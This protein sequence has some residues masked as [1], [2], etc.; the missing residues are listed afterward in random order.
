MMVTVGPA[1]YSRKAGLLSDVGLH[2]NKFGKNAVLIGGN[3]SREIIEETLRKSLSEHGMMV[4][5]SLW[6]GGESSKTNIDRLV[7]QLKSEDFDLLIAAGGG[8]AIDTVKAVAYQ[9]NK[10]LVAIPTI[11]ATC[12]AATPITILYSD[13]GEFLEIGRDSKAPDLVL[14]D[15]H[16]I[17]HA[18]VR[19]LI[20]GIG[21][22]LA[23][24]FETK[25]SIKK[26]VPTAINQTAIAIAGQLYQTLLHIGQAAVTSSQNQTLTKELEDLIDAVILISGSVS[27]YGGDD[28]RTAAA[29]AIYS[30]LT[31]F[32]EIH[33]TYHGEIVAF[34]ILA[35]L[36]MEGAEVEEVQQLIRYYQEVGLPFTLK[37]MGINTLTD[38]QWRELG[39]ITVTIEDMANMPFAVTPS[40]VISAVQMANEIGNGMLVVSK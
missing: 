4:Q 28:C 10:P 5:K 6:Y 16:I 1:Q 23:K 15:S 31:I 34:G 39:E 11:A 26:A 7:D 40:M 27:G 33:Q 21:D 30:G 22:T 35:Q 18:P 38:D 14:V 32:P 9:L 25:C 17:L 29:H 13:E 2:I 20:A 36:C 12:A 19:Y 3:T 37:Q 8:K 24:W